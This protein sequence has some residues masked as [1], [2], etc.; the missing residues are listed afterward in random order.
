MGY[1]TMT[2]SEFHAL[3]A[4][5]KRLLQCYGIER[6]QGWGKPILIELDEVRIRQIEAAVKE[7]ESK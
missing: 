5:A 3:P 6:T 1:L 2:R 7:E 4:T